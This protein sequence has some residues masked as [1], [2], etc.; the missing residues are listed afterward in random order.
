MAL[1]AGYEVYVVT[2]TSGGTSVDAHERSIDRM[3]QAGAVAGD[4]SRCCFEYQRDWSRKETHDAVMDLVREHSG[5][6]RHG[7]GITLIRWCMARQS[8]KLKY[9]F[10]LQSCL[11]VGGF[12]CPPGH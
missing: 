3:V 8:V 9:H 5:A 11:F 12:V 10:I 6:L 1:D 7:R 4:R 2:D